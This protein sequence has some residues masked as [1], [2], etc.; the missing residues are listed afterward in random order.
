MKAA[1]YSV[2]GDPG[3]ITFA[4]V[5]DPVPANNEVLV[6][7]AAI[8]IEGGD[9]LSRKRLP[10]SHTPYIVGYAAAGEVVAVG[11]DVNSLRVGDQVTTFSPRGSHATLRAVREDRCW[12]LPAGMDMQAAACIPVGLGTAYQA[13]FDLGQ[14]RSGQT[15][16]INGAAGGVGLAAVQLAKQAGA[17]VLGT[18]SSDEQLRALRAYGLDEGI[19]YQTEDVLARV[20]ELTG[21]RGVDV[22]IDPVGGASLQIACDALVEQGRAVMV[23]ML[24]S[25][26]QVV[27]A[28]GLLRGRKHLIGC[29]LGNM[30]HE[31]PV[32]AFIQQLVARVASGE[33]NVAI[34]RAFP[35]A[36][37]ADAHRYAETRGRSFG[38][39]VMIP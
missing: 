4:A 19:N 2:N 11:A 30:I 31:P 13:L 37:A 5:P 25:G 14:L 7:N 1:I 26:P 16:L 27:N 20:R 22:A 10:P 18:G 34:D 29:M 15:V 39:V 33:L 24:D 21:K 17:R 36:Q 3:V 9:L 38:R 35:L 32:R 8:S 6:R 23:G 28:A 12:V